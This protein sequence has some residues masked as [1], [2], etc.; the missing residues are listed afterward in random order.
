MEIIKKLKMIF[1]LLLLL[2]SIC[3]NL[4]IGVT[5]ADEMTRKSDNEE[6]VLVT[7]KER[8]DTEINWHITIN[9]LQQQLDEK[10]FILTL[11][12]QHTL[13]ISTL[14]AQL[15]SY[16][17]EITQS[18]TTKSQYVIEF[19]D[20]KQIVDFDLKTSIND[21]NKTDYGVTLAT[22][23][24]GVT[25]EASDGV[26]QTFN[27]VG[28]VSFVNMPD[29]LE[30]PNSE[31]YLIN[32]S[33][34]EKV[35]SVIVDS[36]GKYIFNDVRKFDELGNEMKYKVES[37]LKG[38][39][40][41]DI[42]QYDVKHTYLETSIKGDIDNPTKE[43]LKISL[44]D[45]LTKEV[46]DTLT[47][48]EEATKYEFDSLPVNNNE[49]L[50]IIYEVVITPIEG[51]KAKIE[52]YNIV[53]VK[54]EQE[55]LAED[56]IDIVETTIDT[57][58]TTET[59]TTEDSSTLDPLTNEEISSEEQ[60]T[61]TPISESVLN[62]ENIIEKESITDS[63][64]AVNKTQQS[65][66]PF[67][68]RSLSLGS[69]NIQSLAA[70]TV[71][72]TFTT[73]TPIT[74]TS[75]GDLM[76]M[77]AAL[78]PDATKINWTITIDRKTST[79]YAIEY[80]LY[81]MVFSAG[82]ALDTSTIKQT[83]IN[84]STSTTK[85]LTYNSTYKAI[86]GAYSGLGSN[87]AI[88]SFSTSIT[89]KTLSSYNLSIGG[90]TPAA[91]FIANNI[92]NNIVINGKLIT[93]D[94]VAPEAPKVNA[95]TT[96][97]L[98]VTGTAEPS[99]LVTVLL[100]N[101]LKLTTTADITGKYSVPIPP[102][103]EGAIITV[104]ATDASGNVSPNTQINVSDM[105]S[106]T[107]S[108]IYDN[109]TSVL[110]TATPNSIITI[111]NAAGNVLGTSKV[112]ESGRYY[113]ELY[114][115][116]SAGTIIYAQA[117]SATG[118]ESNKAQTTVL[119]SAGVPTPGNGLPIVEPSPTYI[120]DVNNMTWDERGLYRNRVPLAIEYD[121]GY[122][123]KAAQSTTTPN[124]YAIDL[125]TQGRDTESTVPLDIVLVVDN[126]RSMSTLNSNGMSRWQNM[127][128]SVN[129]FVDSVTSSNTGAVNDT[130]IG[131][132]N[133]ASSIIS[134]TSFQSSATGI[135]SAIP[136]S[137]QTNG[138]LN[139]GTAHT[140][141]QLGI[142]TGSQML[143][144][145]R[146]T[147]KKVMIVLTDG[148]PTFS[149]KGTV[150]TNPENITAF[151]YSKR[152]GDGAVFPLNSTFGNY[153][154]SIGNVAITNH[155]QPTVSE[156]KLIKTAHPDYEIFAI[157]MDTNLMS[158]YDSATPTDMNNVINNIASKQSNAFVT[159]DTAKD[160]PNILSNIAQFTIKSIS[161]GTITD[162]IG[163][164]YDLDLGNNSI[165]DASDYTLTASNPALLNGVTAY[166]D[167]ATKTI[168]LN[169]LTFGKGEWININYKV[170]LRT[171][172]SEFVNGEF[173]PM[174]GRTTLQP[175]PTTTE[176]RD[177]PVPEAKY[178]QP[179]YSFTFNKLDDKNNALSGAVFT[180][181][182]SKG[183][184]Q[185][186]S[187]S[188]NGIVQFTNLLPGNY[189]LKESVAPQGYLLDSTVH[190]VNISSDGLIMVDGLGYSGSLLF[191]FTNKRALGNLDVKKYEAG[192]IDK[193]LPGA[194]FELR[195]ATG[196]VKLTKTTD[197]SGVI[198]F[199]DLPFGTYTLVETKAPL[200]YSLNT[201]PIS[202]NIN[203]TTLVKQDVANSK[204]L[205][206]N[207]GGTGTIIFTVLG[208]C[209]ILLA[210]ILKRKRN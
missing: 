34:N 60:L 21:L 208:I 4:F 93:A 132:V 182:N 196:T 123:W 16:E 172:D 162:P 147:A 127:K 45:Q 38:N 149:Y 8:N 177:Y 55:N 110:G 83:I 74:H 165:F 96:T 92:A 136:A 124:K 167:L 9:P 171:E 49:G 35:S 181:T 31:M 50:P 44:T 25:V 88:I 68:F 112:D 168:K 150:A 185:T 193:L 42:E 61:E 206:P 175:T 95:V 63:V 51:Y 197:D 184:I 90:S 47:I 53:L 103:N 52:D 189:S 77:N 125:K 5:L 133:F 114:R 7:A 158:G 75:T 67:L 41:T 109:Q 79:S 199:T 176:L 17:V 84:G 43:I 37:S 71:N 134:Q 10:R 152:I 135:K 141:T 15:S 54:N 161:G 59:P 106:T 87:K 18:D 48:D 13:D 98:N 174:N 94:N 131:V 65:I 115:T 179:S 104:N 153:A 156:A 180:L 29:D 164:M 64:I 82:Q 56:K 2:N 78:S 194:T 126:S 210:I 130:R 107:I 108:T 200:G 198:H 144:T 128:T 202:V 178:S 26:Y 11:D 117:K 209:L 148:A 73:N 157:G 20:N 121:E 142:R 203:S 160:L 116:Q 205:L 69:T 91:H 166:Y 81:N 14:K 113:V 207:T 12:G 46:V 89:D 118:Q 137:Y 85:A 57:K 139:T 39:Y 102:Q 169:G 201:T 129:N 111:T 190:A 186:A 119:S 40:K 80:N 30:H 105:M 76:T 170:T 146:P 151:D 23:M 138:A 36:D 173:Y 188:G 3:N 27:I 22:E 159:T 70:A 163:E 33:T 6:L 24:N 191:N 192:H 99:S 58:A 19:K 62:E 66:S 97:T 120:G 28:N 140:F 183:I 32:R 100:S 204:A 143:S 101:G 155:G 122:L 154:Y 145:A 1:L 187:S 86:T 72:T 195:D